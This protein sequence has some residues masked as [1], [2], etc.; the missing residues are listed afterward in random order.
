MIPVANKDPKPTKKT[1][2][3]K[4]PSSSEQKYGKQNNESIKAMQEKARKDR[5]TR[6]KLLEER[7]KL[8][9]AV[10]STKE[11]V[12]SLQAEVHRASDENTTASKNPPSRPSFFI[13][14][15]LLIS[16][17]F[18]LQDAQL[19]QKQA[20]AREIKQRLLLKATFLENSKL[21]SENQHQYAQVL[22]SLLARNRTTSY[23]GRETIS[24]QLQEH[25]G[26]A[27]KHTLLGLVKAN[28]RVFFLLLLGLE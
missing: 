13:I 9:L 26:L 14:F 1:P 20:K 10:K 15:L 24:A 2:Q 16:S 11:R 8:R 17:F 27:A 6:E 12:V 19:E 4:P 3:N 7:A 5:K 21:L 23:Q 18:A 22:N 25:V 28:R